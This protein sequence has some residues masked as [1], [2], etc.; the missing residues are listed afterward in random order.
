MQVKA[1]LQLSASWVRLGTLL[2]KAEGCNEAEAADS[3][4]CAAAVAALPGRVR[5]K[6]AALGIVDVVAIAG[7]LGRIAAEVKEEG[8]LAGGAGFVV[9]PA[10]VELMVQQVTEAVRRCSR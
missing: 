9:Q 2:R 7:A 8:D 1:T 6:M 10:L 5:A 3:E 4:A